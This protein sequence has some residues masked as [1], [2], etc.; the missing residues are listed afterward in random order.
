MSE[1][2]KNKAIREYLNLSIKDWAYDL[3]ANHGVRFDEI[4]EALVHYREPWIGAAKLQSA[5]QRWKDK[6]QPHAWPTPANQPARSPGFIIPPP[7]KFT[8]LLNMGHLLLPATFR[9]APPLAVAH[10]SSP[11]SFM[12]TSMMGVDMT[13]SSSPQ[14]RFLHP[15]S[16]MQISQQQHYA[17]P[18]PSISYPYNDVLDNSAYQSSSEVVPPVFQNSMLSQAIEDD[19]NGAEEYAEWEPELGSVCENCGQIVG[20][21]CQCSLYG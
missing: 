20:G 13:M 15:N 7:P 6:E 21:K 14:S 5:I 3:Y 1:S 16:S 2:Q 12:H 18:S 17:A 11:A 10:H 19:T 9:P 4:H 8:H